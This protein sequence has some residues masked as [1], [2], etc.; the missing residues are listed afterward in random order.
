MNFFINLLI[1]IIILVGIGLLTIG[2]KW[3]SAL[4]IISIFLTIFNLYKRKLIK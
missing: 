2:N 3:G 4:I 1:G